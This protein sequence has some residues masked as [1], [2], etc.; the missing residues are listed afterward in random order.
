MSNFERN[1][2]QVATY[3]APDSEDL[4][5]HKTYV[6]PIQLACRW[7]D[8]ANTIRSKLG[9]ELVSKSRVFLAQDISIDGYLFL[10]TSAA[11]DPTVV[12]GAY[13]VQQIMRTPDL[14]NLKTLFVA[15]L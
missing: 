13:E 15:M 11:L 12:A 14:R 3:W 5:G 6:A 8:V 9:T 7:E 2:L 10:G 4:F 1:L